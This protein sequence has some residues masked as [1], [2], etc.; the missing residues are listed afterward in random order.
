MKHDIDVPR[1]GRVPRTALFLLGAALA[2]ASAG[3]LPF[4]LRLPE[5]ASTYAPEIDD[6]FH[7]IMWI[8]GIVFVIVELL[9]VYFLWRYRHREGRT[10]H[11]TH[12]NNRL[13]V[14][15]TIFPA[16]ICVMLALLSRR[17]WTE[18]KQ[19][20]PA[21][22]LQIQVTGEQFAWNIRYPGADGKFGTPDDILTL[23]QLHFPVGKPVVAELTSKDV[24]HSFFLPEFR[25]KQ[26]AVPGM[27][28]KIWFEAVRVGHWEIA[29]AELCGLG[30][31]RMKGFVTVDTPE[32]FEKW[33]AE[34]ASAQEAEQPKAAAQGGAEQKQATAEPAK[35]G[36]S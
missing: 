27:H 11:Y 17:I 14:V 19:R 36:S 34:Q 8:T 22:A 30:H 28:T 31:F 2:P 6:I 7:L 21:N 15:W 29:C 33:L 12:G 3:A 32:D 20:M 5:Q 26:D 10:A 9:L 4:W 16:L 1:A 18:I 23:N 13:E 25:V 24:I 35:G